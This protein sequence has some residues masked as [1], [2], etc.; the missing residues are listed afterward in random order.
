MKSALEDRD[1]EDKKMSKKTTATKKLTGM[2][3]FTSALTAFG[4]LGLEMLL[5]IVLEPML[6]GVE[7]AEFNT[8]QHILHWVITCTIWGIISVWLVHDIKKRC[9]WDIMKKGESM[10][11]W[12]WAVIALG[13][14][15]AVWI[16]SMDWNGLKIVEEFKS[17]GALL[18]TFQYIYYAFETLL[19]MLIIVFGQKAFELW[20]KR[21]DI[22]Y[23]GIICGLTWGLAH[24]FSKGS[25]TTGLWGLALGFLMGV[26]YLLTNRDIKKTYVV[27]FIMFVL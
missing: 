19:F 22:P 5:G 15:L 11:A 21:T 7:M 10:K 14:V 13:C 4:G 16:V 20:F 1:M 27:L 26:A 18:F 25:V 17:R 9:N 23:G 6:Y 8:V 24:V 2:E 3:C 12:Q